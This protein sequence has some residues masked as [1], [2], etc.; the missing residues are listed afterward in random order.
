MRPTDQLPKRIP[1]GS[2]YVLESQG[3]FVRRFIEMPA[4]RRLKLAT[5][6][7]ATCDCL[8]TSIVPM[9]AGD[10]RTTHRRARVLT[11]A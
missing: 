3:G 6:K 2:K 11:R 9:A 7:A 4:G 10:E 1:A 5:R 8:S